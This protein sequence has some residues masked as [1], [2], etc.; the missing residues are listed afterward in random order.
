MGT[1]G[2]EQLILLG[3][4]LGAYETFKWAKAKVEPT[5]KKVKEATKDEAHF[6][7]FE[8]CGEFYRTSKIEKERSLHEA[9]YYQRA[10]EK[11]FKKLRYEF[12]EKY[13][14]SHEIMKL[15]PAVFGEKIIETA[16]AVSVG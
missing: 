5:D 7:W 12:L 16:S 14:D 10:L 11:H 6:G 13:P 1:L 15:Y 9:L 3:K 4:V 2:S 8:D